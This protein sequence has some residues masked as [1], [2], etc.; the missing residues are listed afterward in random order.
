MYA[1]FELGLIATALPNSPAP[2]PPGIVINCAS[3]CTPPGTWRTITAIPSFDLVPGAP[4]MFHPLSAE[5]IA[6]P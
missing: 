3:V 4:T 5:S 1:H 6:E 2:V